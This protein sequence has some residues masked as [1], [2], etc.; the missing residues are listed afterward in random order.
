MPRDK[1]ALLSLT[2]SA[3]AD[4]VPVRLIARE[5]ISESPRKYFQ[6]IY[7]DACVYQDNSL[8]AV[9]DLAGPSHVLYGSDYPHQTGDMPGCLARVNALASGARDNVR[10]RNAARVFRL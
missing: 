10:G 3:S 4:L 8:R 6:H 7:Y 1:R 9:I 5:K 2:S